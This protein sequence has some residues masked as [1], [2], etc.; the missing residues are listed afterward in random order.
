MKNFL[1]VL[2]GLL[3]C[4][5]VYSNTDVP[6]S[7]D[8]T[9]YVTNSNIEKLAD[10]YVD[11]VVSALTVLAK[12]L[13]QPAE[14]VYAVLVKHQIIKAISLLIF[15]I[16]TII[17]LLVI[18]KYEPK[19]RWEDKPYS[20]SDEDRSWN[21]SA[22]IVVI[23]SILGV[24]FLIITCIFFEDIIQGFLNPEYGAIEKILDIVK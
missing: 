6:T 17:C 12:G 10:K 19:S 5:L 13:K 11:K 8:S 18:F 2:F 4:T 23:V 7:N 22:T 24:V 14:H 9:Q 20:R 1:F 15:P 16:L 3:M 21:R